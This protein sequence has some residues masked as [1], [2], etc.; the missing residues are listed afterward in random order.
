MYKSVFSKP[1]FIFI[2]FS[3]LLAILFIFLRVIF[4][5]VFGD[6]WIGSLGLASLILGTVL[7]LSKKEKLGIFGQVLIKQITKTYAG[8]RKWAV[9][10]QLGFFLSVSVFT[11]IAIYIGN[12]EYQS[13]KDQVIDEFKNKGISVDSNLNLDVIHQISSQVTPL[14]QMESIVHF[15]IM[16]TTNYRLFSVILAVSDQLLG[17]WVMYFWQVSIIEILEFLI[18]LRISRK[19]LLRSKKRSL[20]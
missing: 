3:S 19:V 6:V 12:T 11:M 20:Q 10:V 1:V 13:L 16:L 9:Y 18:F 7:F 17:G 15:P 2:S 8:K 14:Q 4:R 5:L